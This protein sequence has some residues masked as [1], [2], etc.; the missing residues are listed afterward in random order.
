MK[1][2]AKHYNVPVIQLQQAV[3]YVEQHCE[4]EELLLDLKEETENLKQIFLSGTFVRRL[5]PEH[6]PH[7]NR[8][9]TLSLPQVQAIE[10][11]LL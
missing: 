11:R 4:D 5:L 9:G 8:Q 2:L 3:A 7:R 1:E 6:R 10:K